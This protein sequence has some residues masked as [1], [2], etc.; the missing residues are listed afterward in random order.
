MDPFVMVLSREAALPARRVGDVLTEEAARRVG[1][2]LELFLERE[3]SGVEE[4]QLRV[5]QVAL[6]GLGAG[7]AE[8]LVV[9]APGDQ[10]WRLVLAEVMMEGLVLR[11]VEPVV[12]EELELDVAVAP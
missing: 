11:D 12:V 3:V 8:D 6:V 1:D 4:V 10:C 7:G 9:R 5:G 2:E